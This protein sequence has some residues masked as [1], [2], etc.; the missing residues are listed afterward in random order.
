[1]E[2]NEMS[3][4]ANVEMLAGAIRQLT[5]AVSNRSFRACGV[6]CLLFKVLSRDEAL[7]MDLC[8]ACADASF[9]LQRFIIEHEGF[10][11]E[12]PGGIAPSR[13]V[14]GANHE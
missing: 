6:A 7:G 14:G 8:A 2:V 13:A 10:R 12:P 5:D 4:T 9:K 1:M 3:T 11:V